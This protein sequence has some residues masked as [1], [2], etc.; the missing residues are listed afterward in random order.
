[1]AMSDPSQWLP[2]ARSAQG[3]RPTGC[4]AQHF[5]AWAPEHLPLADQVA[6]A[7]FDR[8]A[9][10]HARAAEIALHRDRDDLHDWLQRR[11]HDITGIGEESHQDRQTDLF[12]TASPAEDLLPAWRRL[13]D[14]Q[15][16]LAAFA[17]DTSQPHERRTEA[18]GVLSLYERRAAALAA[19]SQRHAPEVVRLGMLMVVPEER[20]AA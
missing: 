14:P 1:M 18:E 3:V 17:G 20:R 10:E 12:A 19:R 8:L 9:A 2:D 11:C 13:D 16:R 15:Q 6:R 4:W 7:H 5:A